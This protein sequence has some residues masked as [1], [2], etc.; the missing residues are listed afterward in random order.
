MFFTDDIT[1]RGCRQI[2]D[3]GHR[4][5][6]AIGIEL[7]VRD[8]EEDNGVDLHFDVILGDDRLGRKVCYLLHQGHLFRDLVDK[9]PFQMKARIPRGVIRAQ[10]FN[11]VSARL[12][13]DVDAGNDGDNN[14]ECQ[15]E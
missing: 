14:D 13:N 4:G 3:C 5:F 8:L 1:E 6:H 11:D 9:G 15:Y 12:R 2:F 7:A 10:S